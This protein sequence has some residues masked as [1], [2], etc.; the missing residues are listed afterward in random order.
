VLATGLGE[1][2]QLDPGRAPET[3]LVTTT[4]GAFRVDGEGRA[5][6]EPIPPPIRAPRP[7][8]AQTWAQLTAGLAWVDPAG[9]LRVGDEVVITGLERARGLTVDRAER[10]YVVSGAEEPRLY[11][12]DDGRLVLI[13]DY[14]GPVVDSLW[15]P[16]GALPTRLLYLLREDGIL[17]YVEP[18]P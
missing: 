13:A 17:E 2:V 12:I 9:T 7:E 16:G 10:I 6:P 8:N 11:R 1:A 5:T 15:G 18:P 3:F 14:V 4:R